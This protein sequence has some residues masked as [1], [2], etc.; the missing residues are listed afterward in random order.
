MPKSGMTMP[1]RR[2]ALP[3]VLPKLVWRRRRGWVALALAIVGLGFAGAILLN[4]AE[5]RPQRIT[6]TA[7]ALNTTRTAV[8]DALVGELLARGVDARLVETRATEDQVAEVEAGR[9]DFALVSGTYRL[10]LHPHL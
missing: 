9:I 2:P 4:G 3:R 10:E 6:L 5:R 1:R 7:G 8:A